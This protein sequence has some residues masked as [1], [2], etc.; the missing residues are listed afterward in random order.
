[1]VTGQE[2]GPF[3]FIPRTETRCRDPELHP[4]AQST[5]AAPS[6]QSWEQ[7]AELGHS[8]QFISS[9]ASSQSMN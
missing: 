6:G 8:L 1:M 7:G 9:E 5:G 4:Q 2:A 3:S